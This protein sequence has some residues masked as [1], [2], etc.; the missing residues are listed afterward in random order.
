MRTLILTLLAFCLCG[1]S[2]VQGEVPPAAQAPGEREQQ[3]QLPQA[4][5]QLWAELARCKVKLD[6][7]TQLYGINVIPEVRALN[8]QTVKAS[9]FIMPLD[10]ADKTKYFLLAK[11]TPV[12]LYCPP[13][14]PNEVIA[15]RSVKPIDWKDELVTV[16]GK[17]TLVNDGEKGIF[18][19]MHDA[20][21]VK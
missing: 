4:K 3:D 11:R 20:N 12:C 18:F 13:G 17:F 7:K 10:G 16:S 5:D 19:E 14:E 21:L 6:A 1:F 15:V 8:G 2:I 9:G